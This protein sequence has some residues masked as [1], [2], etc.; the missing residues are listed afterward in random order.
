MKGT[1]EY[2]LEVFLSISLNVVLFI[3]WLFEGDF[4]FDLFDR[5]FVAFFK[6]KT[7]F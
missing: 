7:L 5:E 3:A 2:A 6:G 1:N 4:F